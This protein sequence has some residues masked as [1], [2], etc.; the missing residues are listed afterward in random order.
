MPAQPSQPTPQPNPS[1]FFRDLKPRSS[2]S[3][4]QA[5]E[6]M[7]AT[8]T[9]GTLVAKIEPGKPIEWFWSTAPTMIVT[10]PWARGGK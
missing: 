2:L 10:D 3:V 6:A 9:G 7:G 4:K 5:L 1:H 8:G